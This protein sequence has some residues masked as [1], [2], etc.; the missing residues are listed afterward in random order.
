MSQ[1]LKLPGLR[2]SLHYTRGHRDERVAD[3]LGRAQ[4]AMKTVQPKI[5]N[6]FF[7]FK[8]KYAFSRGGLPISL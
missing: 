2:A 6:W 8:K 1:L 3:Q 4:A 7:C 5:S